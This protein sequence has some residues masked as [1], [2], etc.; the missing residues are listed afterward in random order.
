MITPRRF[1]SDRSH[2]HRAPARLDVSR[3]DIGWRGLLARGP[4]LTAAL[5][6]ALALA[7]ASTVGAIA[8][9]FKLDG[10][11]DKQ[12]ATGDLLNAEREQHRVTRGELEL[13]TAGH[14]V[15]RDL[16][17]KEQNLR[18]AAESERNNAQIAERQAIVANIR[19]GSAK[20]ANEIV[21][22]ILSR[23]VGGV[24][25]AVPSAHAATP[26]PDALI[27]PEL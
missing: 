12:I 11:R 20:N 5:I 17:R 8:L 26:G 7:T 25:E 16:L 15:T 2:H 24:Q 14:V 9:A 27:D 3:P 22:W 21:A 13:E 23:G 6:A 1:S 19:T 4:L 10:A 18:A